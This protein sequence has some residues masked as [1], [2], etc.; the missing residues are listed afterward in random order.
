MTCSAPGCTRQSRARGLCHAHYEQRRTA[1]PG[2]PL[3]PLGAYRRGGSAS[4]SV[5]LPRALYAR[6]A[7][8]AAATGATLAAV[9][10]RALEAYFRSEMG[11]A[12]EN[13]GGFQLCNAGVQTSD[14]LDGGSEA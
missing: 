10:E 8:N 4:L 2:E 6:L 14:S 9:V 7:A 13:T 3:K 1:A 5:R 12:G 11:Q